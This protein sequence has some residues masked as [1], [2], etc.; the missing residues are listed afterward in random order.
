MRLNFYS[1][2]FGL[3]IIS[4]LSFGVYLFST[5]EINHSLFI[6]PL[7]LIVIL[8]VITFILSILTLKDVRKEKDFLKS[9]ILII[10]SGMYALG[11]TI[12]F[13]IGKFLFS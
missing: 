7:L 12:L 11:L 3:L 10:L 8:S 2:V 1:T 5:P 9:L 13:L 4:V 6:H